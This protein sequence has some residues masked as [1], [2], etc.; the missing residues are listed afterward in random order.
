MLPGR[1]TAEREPCDQRVALRRARLLF[2]LLGAP[3][4]SLNVLALVVRQLN[5]N[6][7]Q[8]GQSSAQGAPAGFSIHAES[9]A[10]F[11]GLVV[12]DIPPVWPLRTAH[13]SAFQQKVK[14]HAWREC[15]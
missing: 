14:A 3:V 10:A 4:A 9:A 15:R 6:L 8:H 1:S 12:Q 5:T 2:R 11:E 7:C 13:H